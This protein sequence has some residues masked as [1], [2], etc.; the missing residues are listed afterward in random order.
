MKGK[1]Q[2]VAKPQFTPKPKSLLW[3]LLLIFFWPFYMGERHK[4]SL[5]IFK[6]QFQMSTYLSLEYISSFIY[7]KW[8]RESSFF[9]SFSEI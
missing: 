4:I 8:D 9:N 2:I 5:L 1:V 7:L 6:H 3:N